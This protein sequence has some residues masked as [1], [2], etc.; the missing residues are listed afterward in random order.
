MSIQGCRFRFAV[1]VLVSASCAS[2]ERALYALEAYAGAL[3][4]EC[5]VVAADAT[6]DVSAVLSSIEPLDPSQPQ[7]YGSRTCGGFVFEY[8]NPDRAPLRGAWIQASASADLV[9]ASRC[10]GRVLEAAYWGYEKREWIELGFASSAAGS[11]RARSRATGI[12]GSR[13]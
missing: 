2:D 4:P 6:G 10:H 5:G 7:V 9:D 8:E 13:H 11:S 12:V 1:V 3:E